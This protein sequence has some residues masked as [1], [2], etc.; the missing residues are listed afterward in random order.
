M[1]EDV[2]AKRLGEFVG[3][4]DRTIRQLVDRGV[5]VRCGRNLYPLEEN[6]RRYAAHLREVASGRGGEEEVATL[7]AERARLAREQAD[8]HALKN[9]TARGELIPGGEV[10]ARWEDLARRVRSQM[11][12]VPSRVRE[13]APHLAPEHVEIIDREIRGALQDLAD[14]KGRT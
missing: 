5:M 1:S 9:A 7:T 4:N 6:V 8:G 2:S 3:L 12:A 13:R 14:R 11:M 10:S